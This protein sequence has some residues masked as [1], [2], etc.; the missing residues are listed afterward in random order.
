MG[1][2]HLSVCDLPYGVNVILEGKFNKL[3]NKFHV[4]NVIAPHIA[5]QHKFQQNF[6]NKD[7]V[8]YKDKQMLVISEPSL[9]QLLFVKTMLNV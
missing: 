9:D 8:Q 4:K 1:G 2:K 5:P 3:S 7:G 6:V